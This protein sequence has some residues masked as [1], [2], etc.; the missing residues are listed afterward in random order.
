MSNEALRFYHW[1]NGQEW[2]TLRTRD[3]SRQ[4]TFPWPV[5]YK[6]IACEHLTIR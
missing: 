1:T 3:M 2:R 4:L 6:S 5:T